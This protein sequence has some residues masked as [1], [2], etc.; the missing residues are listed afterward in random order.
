MIRVFIDTNILLGFYQAAADRLVVFKTLGEL[1][2]RIVF[3]TQTRMEF[4]RNRVVILRRIAKLLTETTKWSPY[5]TSIIRA[6]P[7][8]DDLTRVRDETQRIA[9]S[10]CEALQRAIEEP[11]HDLVLAEF[12]KL[13]GDST[14]TKVTI[15]QDLI[16]R[17][18]TRKLLGNPPTSPDK[19]T[20]G[21]EVAWE[22]LLAN[23]HDD[24]IVVSQD[25]TFLDNQRLL[26]A[27]YEERTGAKLVAVTPRVSE[28]IKLLGETPPKEI[29]AAD[30]T[31]PPLNTPLGPGWKVVAAT[32]YKGVIQRDDGLMTIIDLPT[33]VSPGSLLP[34]S[35]FRTVT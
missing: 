27:E 11:E 17:A 33:D 1:R 31:L 5:T 32:A 9:K 12:E 21:D 20:A 10:M 14:V 28:A 29:I 6:L 2:S 25:N 23:L 26:A 24:L 16:G 15:T 18:Q 7:G 19:L 22:A 8:F 3:T 34:P 13:Y 35:T 4:E 30:E